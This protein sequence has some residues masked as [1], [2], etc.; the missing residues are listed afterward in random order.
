MKNIMKSERE[1][2]NYGSFPHNSQKGSLS[3][4]KFLILYTSF[5]RR[6]Q[7]GR[8]SHVINFTNINDPRMTR[9]VINTDKSDYEVITFLS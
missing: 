7:I 1:R 8:F 3:Y 4:L 9:S 5:V 6:K 2:N